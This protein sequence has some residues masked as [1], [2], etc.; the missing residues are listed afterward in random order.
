MV[1]GTAVIQL[2][3]PGIHSLKQKRSLLKGLI[4]RL[5]KQFNISCGEVD[6]HDV[7][8]SAAIGIALVSTSA[9]HADRALDRIVTWIEDN[10]PDVMVVDHH[11][12]IIS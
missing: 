9:A 1:I 11:I 10:R 12:E 3:L 7:W 6:F 8:Q 2:S 4:A 5:H